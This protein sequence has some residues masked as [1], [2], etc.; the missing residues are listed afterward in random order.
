MVR[1]GVGGLLEHDDRHGASLGG[2]NLLS[3]YASLSDGPSIKE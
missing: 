3:A 1:G 2:S